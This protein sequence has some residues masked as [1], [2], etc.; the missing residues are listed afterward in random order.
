MGSIADRE[1]NQK[2]LQYRI[3]R[4]RRAANVRLSIL[5]NQSRSTILT[6]QVISYNTLQPKSNR[7]LL[8]KIITYE[9]EY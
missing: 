2:N 7:Q 3:A 8:S 6:I 1:K 4:R 5:R 9:T